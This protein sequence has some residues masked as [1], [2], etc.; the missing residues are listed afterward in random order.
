MCIY[1]PLIRNFSDSGCT[2]FSG[3]EDSG[4]RVVAL[5]I[6]NKNLPC[7]EG[8]HHRMETAKYGLLMETGHGNPPLHLT[9]R[10]P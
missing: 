6:M 1:V 8:G 5:R 7:L 3:W 4:D 9:E 2:V 10:F